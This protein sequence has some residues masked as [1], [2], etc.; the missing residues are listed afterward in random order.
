MKVIIDK[1]NSIIKPNVVT[2]PGN[3]N[4]SINVAYSYSFSNLSVTVK[5]YI[6]TLPVYTL[7]SLGINNSNLNVQFST[8]TT[9]H[10]FLANLVN[11]KLL[12]YSFNRKVITSTVWLKDF[13]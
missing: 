5:N 2:Y 6:N 7:S 10:Y 12:C 1:L 4:V 13:N 9:S 3:V 11:E 8:L